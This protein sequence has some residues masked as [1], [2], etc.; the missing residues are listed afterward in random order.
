MKLPVG[1][2]NFLD[3][4]ISLMS[5]EYADF[6]AGLEDAKFCQ[7]LAAEVAEEVRVLR[8]DAEYGNNLKKKTMQ[9]L[10]DRFD[11][12]REANSPKESTSGGSV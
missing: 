12:I 11:E 8:A 4:T 7:D 10:N 6:D 1:F 9:V 2:D 5:P 3:Y